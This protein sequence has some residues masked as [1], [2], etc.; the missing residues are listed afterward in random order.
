MTKVNDLV[1]SYVRARVRDT[2]GR[3]N[4]EELARPE[5]RMIRIEESRKRLNEELVDYGIEIQ[6]VSATDWD[7]DDK[8]EEMIRRRKEAD[9][10]FV[11]QATAQETNRKKQETNIAEQ[12]RLK[13]NAMAEAQGNAQQE[14]IAKQ[15][16]SVEQRAGADGQ[17][18]KLK[19]DADAAFIKLGNDAAAL[20]TEL[21]RRAQGVQA[22]ADAYA[23]GGLG[24]VKEAL[25]AKLKGVTIT[26]RPF[27]WDSAPQRVQMENVDPES[28]GGGRK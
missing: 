7:Y 11:N 3:L 6:T 17:S 23:K 19:K 10:I 18:Y 16:W 5:E 27:S 13:S 2:I 8:Y 25:A 4:L 24:L 28:L 22:L 21:T 20:E 15:A 9:Q 12:N 26:G 1:Y 14:I